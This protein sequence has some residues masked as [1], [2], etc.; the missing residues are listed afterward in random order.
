MV[1][2]CLYSIS[3]GNLLKLREDAAVSQVTM[4]LSVPRI[5]NRIVEGVKI[6]LDGLVKDEAERPAI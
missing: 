1:S 6:T 2:V 5:Y 3:S 4:F